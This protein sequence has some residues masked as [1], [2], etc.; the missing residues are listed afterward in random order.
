[1]RLLVAVAGLG[2][3]AVGALI[4]GAVRAVGYEP[5]NPQAYA[6]PAARPE[7]S[8]GQV[9]YWVVR[10]C[11][12]GGGKWSQGIESGVLVGRCLPAALPHLGVA[13]VPPPKR[14]RGG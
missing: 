2:A 6:A 3:L 9:L 14:R 8:T 10:G 11:A 5:P 13:A 7:E 12:E 4:F 1:M